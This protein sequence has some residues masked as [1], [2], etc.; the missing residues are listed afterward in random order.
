MRWR[1]ANTSQELFLRAPPHHPRIWT[2]RRAFEPVRNMLPQRCQID[3]S[4]RRARSLP[5]RRAL[6]T[7]W[8]RRRRNAS[9][10]ARPSLVSSR[11]PKICDEVT[12]KDSDST[13][14]NMIQQ[15]KQKHLLAPAR[16]LNSRCQ[17][18]NPRV[19]IESKH[20]LQKLHIENNV[21]GDA[22]TF[23]PVGFFIDHSLHL[24]RRPTGP[25][26]HIA[27]DW[28]LRFQHIRLDIAGK[29]INVD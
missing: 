19:H 5:W 28:I 1:R 23:Q 24:R 13:W 17:H 7:G 16:C 4:S 11:A 12:R 15:G 27:W 2:L 22:M 8:R 3:G 14:F 20:H 10:C 18:C 9:C 6:K 25:P 21:S 29:L 26:G